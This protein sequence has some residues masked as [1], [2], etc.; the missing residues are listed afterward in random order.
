MSCKCNEQWFSYRNRE[1][2]EK[3]RQEGLKKKQE[4]KKEKEQKGAE[5]DGILENSQGVSQ[6]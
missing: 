5:Q 3:K 1:E 2:W 4:L 6:S